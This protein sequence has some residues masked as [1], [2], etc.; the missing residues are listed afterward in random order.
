MHEGR[1]ACRACTLQVAQGQARSGTYVIKA[2]VRAPVPYAGWAGRT[3]GEEHA[4]RLSL[5][6]EEALGRPWPYFPRLGVVEQAF[7]GLPPV[8]LARVPPA[9]L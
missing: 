5:P 9:I 1:R 7:S 8:G 4:D 2:G 3:V 6:P